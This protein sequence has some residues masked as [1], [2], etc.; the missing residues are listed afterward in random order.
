LG[1][2]YDSKK[3]I[4]VPMD[5]EDEMYRGEYYPRRMADTFVSIE[6][7]N[8]FVDS[9]TENDNRML[10]VAGIFEEKAQADSVLTLAKANYPSAKVVTTELYMG[11]MH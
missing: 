5:D 9:T 6:M 11:C 1:R 4:I 7:R 10:L 3:G 2:I 8:A